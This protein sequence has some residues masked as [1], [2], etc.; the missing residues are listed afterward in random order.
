M[1]N[2]IHFKSKTLSVNQ[3]ATY[4]LR[5]NEK[6]KIEKIQ[7]KILRFLFIIYFKRKVC[8]LHET[9]QAFFYRFWENP[10]FLNLGI[11]MQII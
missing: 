7:N 3:K 4:K 8:L 5:F 10:T 9:G 11:F 6:L 2:S 1:S